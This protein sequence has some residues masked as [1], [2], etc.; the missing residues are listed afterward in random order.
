MAKI[1]LSLPVTKQLD[2]TNDLCLVSINGTV[3][4]ANV[5]HYTN[6]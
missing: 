2:A 6:G 3:P 1:I 4:Q 5:K